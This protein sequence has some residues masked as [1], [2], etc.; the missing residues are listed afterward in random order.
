MGGS[1]AAEGP[2]GIVGDQ[3]RQRPPGLG[4]VGSAT[5]DGSGRPG[6]A[7]LFEEPM[8]VRAVSLEGEEQVARV[9]GACIDGR[10]V[11]GAFEMRGVQPVRDKTVLVKTA[12]IRPN[13]EPVEINYLM[14]KFPAGWKVIDV[15]VSLVVPMVSSGASGAP[16]W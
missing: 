11:A 13:D 8:A 1:Q 4:E 7:G 9:E 2:S 3:Q 16:R 6:D 5:D 12:I 10:T 14:R 15:P